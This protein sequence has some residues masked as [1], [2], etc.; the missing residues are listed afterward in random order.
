M[1]SASFGKRLALVAM[2]AL[3][4]RLIVVVMMAGV[5][6]SPDVMTDQADYIKM[7]QQL[8]SQPLP[9]T[10]F[11]RPPAYPYMV[12]GVIK[13][14]EALGLQAVSLRVS[15]GLLQALMSAATVVLVALLVRRRLNARV[16]LIAAW[17]LA[18][19]PNQ[20]LAT[21]SIMTE[22]LS[23]PLVVASL[24]VLWWNPKPSARVVTTS[25]VLLV[26][27]VLTRPALWPMLALLAL[28]AMWQRRGDWGWNVMQAHVVGL[29][30]L[31][32]LVL[33][34]SWMY[35]GHQQ[36]GSTF[37]VANSGGYNLCLGHNPYATGQWTLAD[38]QQSYCDWGGNSEQEVAHQALS[39]AVSHP[40][41]ELHLLFARLDVTMSSDSD[42]L[43][44]YSEPGKWEGP[45]SPIVLATVMYLWWCFVL[46]L[47]AFGLVVVLSQKAKLYYWVLAMGATTLVMP[48]LTIGDQRF[49]DVLV[50]MMALLGAEAWQIRDHPLARSRQ[51]RPA[52]VLPARHKLAQTRTPVLV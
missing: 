4:L 3:A 9:Y 29:A 23:T 28:Y 35:Y 25:S 15:M 41:Q 32:A 50:P 10:N 19:W 52:T 22:R 43:S 27:A 47:T 36:T 26:L 20:V 39:W 7:G 37:M 42:S 48:L 31:P 21:S 14:Q 46:V 24:T 51:L 13:A 2:V 6:A 16:A 45:S 5:P 34:G 40:R 18:L 30:L 1:Q 8:A 49:H 44:L 33:L 38:G 12:A 11:F 17:L